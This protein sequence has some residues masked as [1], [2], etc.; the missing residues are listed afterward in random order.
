MAV[1]K[2]MKSCD[3]E[4]GLN[5]FSAVVRFRN[6][7]KGRS[8]RETDLTQWKEVLSSPEIIYRMDLLWMEIISTLE[9]LNK[10]QNDYPPRYHNVD[11]GNFQ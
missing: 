6:R 8:H 11:P 7:T 10:G 2:C 4:G 9:E 3:V 5:K 1:F